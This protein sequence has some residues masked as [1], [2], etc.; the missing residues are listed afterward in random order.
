MAPRDPLV[1][2]LD[3]AER[4]AS[5]DHTGR[6]DRKH[7]APKATTGAH[8]HDVD[9]L[10]IQT[11]AIAGIH[12]HTLVYA[13][14]LNKTS[15]RQASLA[16]SE[17][18]TDR[19]RSVDTG[20]HMQVPSFWLL[21]A[22][23]VLATPASAEEKPPPPTDQAK[24]EEA[25][26]PK[27][28]NRNWTVKSGRF[29]VT[30]ATT[31]GIPEPDQVAEV[32]ILAG[33]VPE[34]ADPRFGQNQPLKDARILIHLTDPKGETE[35]YLAHPIP[36]AAG[37]YGIHFTPKHAG[38]YQLQLKGKTAKGQAVEAKMT[39]PVAVWPLPAELQGSGEAGGPRVR[40][41]IRKPLGN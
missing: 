34:H 41:V 30:F 19:P 21:A 8:E 15:L 18:L 7:A 4:P 13:E 16:R 28:A 17:G 31:P 33:M 40:Q 32:L 10:R 27:P 37:R 22:G 35:S 20:S 39:L 3:I 38:L 25:P 36:R 26:P 5:E 23:L 29:A 14:A 1:V 11:S 2:E 9:D 6:V 24:P 12:E